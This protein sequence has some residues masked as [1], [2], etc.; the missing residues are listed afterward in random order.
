MKV[1]EKVTRWQLSTANISDNIL[2][3][4]ENAIISNNLGTVTMVAQD[5]ILVQVAT[6]EKIPVDDSEL[7]L[8]PPTAKACDPRMRGKIYQALLGLQF[9]QVTIF[10][11][12]GRITRVERDE[13]IR[14]RQTHGLDGDGI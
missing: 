9:G 5:G 3:F 12:K 10:V 8:A 6:T 1:P 4:I 2:R 7:E 11:D 13:R 14:W